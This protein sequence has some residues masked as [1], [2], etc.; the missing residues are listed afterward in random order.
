[1]ILRRI[2]AHVEKENWF[3]V[4]LDFCIVVIGVFVGLQVANWNENLSEDRRERAYLERLDKEFDVVEARISRAIVVGEIRAR[5][6][7]TLLNAWA[8]GPEAFSDPDA[9]GPG[10]LFIE[11]IANVVPTDP[12][13]AFRELVSSGE[14]SIIES[15][16]LRTALYEFDELS[17]VTQIAYETTTN[18]MRT[19]REL[20]YS[21]YLFEIESLDALFRAEQDTGSIVQRS[22]D[23]TFIPE[24][25]FGNP[26]FRQA[27]N[28]AALS[29]VNMRALA[30]RQQA[31]LE[32]IIALIEEELAP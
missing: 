2:K 4:F 3:A 1:M 29:I 7:E 13:A 14:L 11:I 27:L 9:K 5:A 25:F 23:G 17:E 26:D 32:R 21:A 18:D 8:V 22:I 30:E 16:D 19:L 15:A 20:M 6:T 12:P 31:M 28:G 24:A 10:T